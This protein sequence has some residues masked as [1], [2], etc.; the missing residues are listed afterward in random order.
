MAIASSTRRRSNQL[1]PILLLA[2][3]AAPAVG[4]LAEETSSVSETPGDA[5]SGLALQSWELELRATERGFAKTMVD[6]D[7]EAFASFLAEDTVFLGGAPLRGKAAV[8][9]GWKRFYEA[10]QP[11]F[12]WEP[13][14]VVVL[15]SGRLGLSTGPVHDPEGTRIGTFNSIWQRDPT[16]AWKIVFDKGC[17]CGQP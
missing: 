9:E 11:P 6:R 3:L 7:L 17:D 5:S 2:A 4:A 14:T 8:V 16:G 15:E 13:E 1:L 12:S 10:E